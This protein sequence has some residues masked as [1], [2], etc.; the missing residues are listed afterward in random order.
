[1]NKE[2]LKI[3]NQEL[4]KVPSEKRP[5]VRRMISADIPL[6]DALTVVN[7]FISQ[8]K[9][10]YTDKGENIPLKASKS[11]N[12][13][14]N[15][16]KSAMIE[17]TVENEPPSKLE[18]VKNSPLFDLDDITNKVRESIQI[19]C[20]Q[21][22]ME[23]TDMIKAPQRIWAACS[24]YV[25]KNV[26]KASGLLK[27]TELSRAVGQPF[28]TTN[29][30]LDIDKV[31]SAINLYIDLCNEYNKAVLVDYIALFCGISDS[32]I[33]ENMEKLTQKGMDLSK[34][35]ECSLTASLVDGKTNP[36]GTIATLN[37][38][39]GWTTGTSHTEKKETIIIYPSL[40]QP[41]QTA[42][43]EQKKTI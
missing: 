14:I 30:A 40:S 32:W 2:E 5:I 8:N 26:F 18:R 20:I 15:T 39:H 24:S 22:D 17:E 23:N 6:S 37:H 36:T 27:Q 12:K 1:M 25:G 41:P 3:L 10:V 34:K 43:I 29:N 9:T 19:Y 16:S 33:Y 11:Q 7:A 42:T 28:M 13:A 38:F 35:R 21:H 31:I 4:K